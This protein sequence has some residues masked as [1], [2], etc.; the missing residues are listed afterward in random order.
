[1]V[2]RGLSIC[3]IVFCSL[4]LTGAGQAA[5]TGDEGARASKFIESLAD[6]AIAALTE[7][8]VSREKRVVRFR[9]LLNEHFA[10]ETIGRWVLGRYWNQ[11]TE[12]ERKEYLALF[13][14]LIV[15]T[16]VDRF[17]SYSGEK[18]TVT[19]TIPVTGGDLLV[20][21]QITRPAGGEPLEV[22]WRVRGRDGHF[23]IVDVVVAG[24]SMGQ[25]QRSEFSS[26]IR[27]NGG[28]VEGLLA[29]LREDLK[30]GA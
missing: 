9:A 22:G 20:N 6:K 25:T 8:S 29:K 23:K 4:M 27:R 5:G 30:K 3:V 19:S 26:V 24:V 10:V 18:L 13:E 11:A 17:K 12:P 1:M 21:S 28:D 16:Y 15:T 7:E 2:K 14:D